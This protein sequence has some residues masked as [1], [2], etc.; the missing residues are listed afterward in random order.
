MMKKHK[1]KKKLNKTR[2]AEPDATAKFM[3]SSKET[4]GLQPLGLAAQAPL[5]PDEG[6]R[7]ATD[8]E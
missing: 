3:E 4:M 7:V 2:I 8:D 1:T 6:I 5:A